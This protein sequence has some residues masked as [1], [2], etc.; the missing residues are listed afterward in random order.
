MISK[1]EGRQEAMLRNRGFMS[2]TPANA[3]LLKMALAG[4][5]IVSLSSCSSIV[6]DQ[7]NHM[8]LGSFGSDLPMPRLRVE[9]SL[10]A[11]GQAPS[12]NLHRLL[13]NFEGGTDGA[14]P[15][16]GLVGDQSGNLF[17]TTRDGGGGVC[18]GS[19]GNG[20]GTAFEL[21]LSG[22]RYSERLIHAFGSG[23]DGAHPDGELIRD[24]SGA[25]YGTT[26]DG[27]TLG[28]GAIFKLA[29]AQA[30]YSES[31]IYSFQGGSDGSHPQGGLILDSSG[32]LYG[33]TVNGGGGCD[34]GTAFEL[35]KG[36]STYVERVM[37]SFEGGSDGAFPVSG[38]L[39]DQG[40]LF[41]TTAAGGA[42][43]LGTVFLL[44]PA[45]SGY[46]EKI[47]YSFQGEPDGEAPGS[48]LI[49][50]SKGSLFGTTEYGGEGNCSSGGGLFGCG[51]VFQLSVSGSTYTE[52]ILYRF[53]GGSDGIF[54][55]GGLVMNGR[56]TLFGTTSGG[57]THDRCEPSGCGTVFKV[58]FTPSGSSERVI[59]DFGKGKVSASNPFGNLLLL[60]DDLYGTTAFG[61]TDGDGTVFRLRP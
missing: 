19:G 27:G 52:K 59:S 9:K 38:L 46:S 47:I 1:S 48:G 39:S 24:A 35:V 30:G 20:C 60:G 16:A 54:P 36:G 7:D 57:G 55:L 22:G 13:Y 6:V 26:H 25:F 50:N 53:V 61:G 51:T 37:H 43:S 34:C 58:T 23:G 12:T 40:S 49:T 32:N 3:M 8:R 2:Q 14:T 15:I 5:T 44:S 10:R 11:P 21:Q 33:T 41:G 28:F 31:V 45:P 56:G 4:L 42:E 18:Q 17:G 29:P